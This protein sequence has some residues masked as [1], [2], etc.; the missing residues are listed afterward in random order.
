MK[1]LKQTGMLA[2]LAVL[3]VAGIAAVNPGQDDVR[4]EVRNVSGF[5]GVDIGGAMTAKITVGGNYEVVVEARE[6][7]LPAIITEVK[8]GRLIVKHDNDWWKNRGDKKKRGKVLVTV[9]LP[10]LD[11]LDISGATNAA[12]TGVN[13]DRLKIDVSGASNVSIQGSARSTDIDLSGASSLKA[14]DLLSE[15]SVIDLSGASSAKVNV[16]S[17][18]RAD[19]S[20]A[21]SVCYAGSPRVQ[22]DTS[23]ASSVRGG[24]GGLP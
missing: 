5:T 23:G 18:L 1:I 10:L 14:L 19:A 21:S 15:T 2:G 8:N 13:S 16:T 22:K 9:S 3:A 17:E 11:D 6:E 4:S 7:V 24:C 12:V 20:G